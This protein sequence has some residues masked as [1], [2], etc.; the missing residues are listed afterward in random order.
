MPES[1]KVKTFGLLMHNVLCML[2]GAVVRSVS[3]LVF[4]M[5]YC[6]LYVNICIQMLSLLLSEIR[7]FV[8]NR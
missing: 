3:E 6:K 4:V 7:V 2:H 8:R 5:K 1:I